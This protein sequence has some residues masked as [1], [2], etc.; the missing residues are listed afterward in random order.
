MKRIVFVLGTL[1]ALL[2][3]GLQSLEHSPAAADSL[4]GKQPTV[5]NEGMVS[6][7]KLADFYEEYGL[8]DQGDTDSEEGD[9]DDD[10]EPPS[11]PRQLIISF[12]PGITEEEIE[13]FYEE[14]G[15]LEEEDLDGDDRDD[16]EEEKLAD[17]SAEVTDELIS[18]LDRDPRTEYVERNY[19]L[20][21]ALNPPDDLDSQLWGLNNTGQSGGTADAD[22]DAPE[23]W[24]ITT[25]SPDVIVGIIDTGVNYNHED[26]AANMWSNPGEIPGNGIDDDS[27]G[28]ID[29]IHG[30]NAITNSGDPNDDHG[31]GTHTAGT[32]GAVG[33][34]GL[35]V[36]GVN[37]TVSIAGCKFLSATG[38][39][40]TA[41]AVKC[42]KYFNYL[43]HVQGQN[44]VVTNKSWG[45]GGFSQAL[46]DAMAGLDQPGMAPILHAAAAG[47][48]SSN[49]D[50]G[51]HYPSSYTL[52][53]IVAVAATDRNDNYAS[54]SSYG[55]TSVDL[56]APGDFILSTY[57]P[58]NSYAILN[59][60]SMATPH[61]AGAAALISSLPADPSLTA[62]QLK[63]RLLSGADA[64]SDLSKQTA[65]NGRLNA[66]NALE[67]DT[68]TPAMVNNLA[69]TG[70]NLTSVTLTW[71]A[72]GDDANTGTAASYDVRYSSASSFNWATA[73]P[74]VGEPSPQPAGST[75]VFT[76]S[77]LDPSTPYEFAMKVSDNVG[78]QS[79]LSN[80]ATKSTTTG[81]VVFGDDMENGPEGWTT[82]G[83]WHLS[84]CRSHGTG[85][86]WYYGLEATAVI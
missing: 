11:V 4:L 71:A 61:V 54:F 80:V 46:E 85:N 49:N 17:T 58:G 13:D 81:T 10:A 6:K 16:D 44:V 73:T 15:L 20:S 65:T 21:A 42:F 66:L 32:I 63:Q 2:M 30:I 8:L 60:T 50:V 55:A 41:N 86:S 64:L 40:T 9:D 25:G 36:V 37:W 72:T 1:L 3:L 19:I 18:R 47:N 12:H 79:P 28:Y 5:P 77:G 69:A 31:H 24:D 76:V 74:A 83:F 27:N 67:N 62:A 34:N 7:E 52:D 70:S 35:G 82:S 14:Y 75:E 39:G 26:L 51:P 43:K 22:I 45:G 68:T 23:A 48:A 84:G 38:S 59:G 33:N 53:N 57:Q 78:N 29:D 56:A